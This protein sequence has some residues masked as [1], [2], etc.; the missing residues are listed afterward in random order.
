MGNKKMK[1]LIEVKKNK[2]P[3]LVG[4]GNEEIKTPIEGSVPNSV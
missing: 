4:T 2:N 1:K 3:I